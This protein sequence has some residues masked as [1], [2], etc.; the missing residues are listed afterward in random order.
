M[1]CYF[2]DCVAPLA[3]GLP[4]AATAV[5]VGSG[6][7]FPGIPLAIM[8]PGTRFTLVDALARRVEFLQAVI[9]RLGLNAV[10]LHLRAEDAARQEPLREGFD[11]AVARA[12]AP[13]NV[14]CEYMLPL[15]RVG[16]CMLALKGP[17]LDEE[18]AQAENALSLL[19]GGISRVQSLP[20]P[21][22]DWDHRA[23]WIKKIAPTPDKYP[24]RAGAVEKRPL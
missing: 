11:L 7:G 4:E 1:D 24:R 6:A 10:A 19:G 3:M 14:L 2:L 20:I 15:L 13:M 16:G 12:V 21:G 8:L 17:G 18:L 23:V 5:D 22:R 9:D